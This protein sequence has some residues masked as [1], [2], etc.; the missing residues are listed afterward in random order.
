MGIINI[1]WAIIIIDDVYSKSKSPNTPI[2]EKRIY[3]NNPITTGGSASSEL[4]TTCRNFL[5]KKLLT[6]INADKG[7][8]IKDAT[9][10][11]VTETYKD[12][13]TIVK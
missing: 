3:K 4:I 13:S 1:T 10:V 7:I 6:T 2:L 5:R 9:I 11:A 8:N 12:V